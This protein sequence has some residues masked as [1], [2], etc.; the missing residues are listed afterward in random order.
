MENDKDILANAEVTLY[1]ESDID[2]NQKTLNA[3]ELMTAWKSFQKLRHEHPEL[4][5]LKST[6]LASLDHIIQ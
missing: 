6:G 2:Y 1:Q 4:F 3:A 5:G